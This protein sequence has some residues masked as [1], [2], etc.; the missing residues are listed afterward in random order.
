MENYNKMVLTATT[1][2][3]WIYPECKN[4]AETLDA[5]IEDVYQCYEAGATIAHVHL[6]RGKEIETVKRIR[7]RCDILIQA[8]MS[9]DNISERKGDIE[10]RPDMMSI[11][12]NHH[13]EH[14]TQLSVNKLHPLD[15]LKEYCEICKNYGIKPE[16]EVW[17][18]GSFWNLNYLIDK[19]LVEPPNILTLFFNWPGGTWSPP[20][21]DEYLHRIKY[22]PENSV[23]TVSIMGDQQTK[24]ATLAISKGGNVRVGTEDY[25]Y[26]KKGIPAKNNAEIV[27]RMKKISEEMGREVATPS[28]GR[29][30]LGL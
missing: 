30:I 10:S 12:L 1:A 26:I 13:D 4:W 28:E 2:N 23:H 9:S 17:H 7:E 16:W 3:S 29:E 22:M 24:I 19:H 21:A 25:P 27:K 6:P 14:F 20:T 11:I 5:L 18:T 15:E 8:G